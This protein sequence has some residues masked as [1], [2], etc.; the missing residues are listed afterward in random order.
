MLFRSQGGFGDMSGE[1]QI[2]WQDA[3]VGAKLTVE[4]PHADGEYEL[5]INACRARDY[6]IHQLYWNGEKL[7]A[8]IDFYD[9]SLLW[10]QVKLGKVKIT[11]GKAI[12]TAECVGANPKADPRRMFGL[13]YLLLKKL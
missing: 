9:P 13:D 10:K 3:P 4:V 1:G 8:P 11:G 2:W 6:G 7:G 12:L 5:T